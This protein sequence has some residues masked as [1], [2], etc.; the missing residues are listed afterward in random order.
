MCKLIIVCGLPASGKTTLAKELSRRLKIA[1]IH[2][3]SI[4][5][6]LFDE[7]GLST[8]D[9]SKRLGKPSVATLFHLAKQQ[10][11][12]DVDLII[13]APFN[14]PEDYPLFEEW[15]NIYDI[16][17]H[18]IVCSINTEERKRRFK[19]RERHHAH[20]D[21]DRQLVRSMDQQ[22]HDYANIPG[23]QIRITTDKSVDELV[24]EV[25]SQ[26]K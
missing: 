22:K 6:C 2:K 11:E 20:H 8:L 15:R 10:I 18:T 3:D 1:C 17:L 7:L 12:N 9:D 4:K 23:K 21:I 19:E 26:I 16:E 5:E 25:V 13:E 24:E 14:F